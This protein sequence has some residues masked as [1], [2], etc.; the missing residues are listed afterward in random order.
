[1]WYKRQLLYE[2]FRGRANTVD[3]VSGAARVH[4]LGRVALRVT[5]LSPGRATLYLEACTQDDGSCSAHD[6]VTFQIR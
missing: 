3:E 2:D 4:G 5:G 6:E 1:M